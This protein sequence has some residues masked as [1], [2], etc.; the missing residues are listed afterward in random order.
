[1]SDFSPEIRNAAWWS[2]D[3]RLAADGRAFDAV[4][5]KLGKKAREDISHLEHVRMGHV[6]QPVIAK[7][8]EEEHKQRVVEFD[9]AVTHVTESWLRSHF[10]YITEDRRTLVECKN[11]NAHA[12]NKFSEPGEPVRIPAADRA[13]CIHEAT[14]AGVNTVYLAVLFGGQTFRSFRIDVTDEDKA[15]LVREMAVY[16]GMV[17]T[18]Q[19]PEPQTAEQARVAWPVDDGDYATAEE[20]WET[21]CQKLKALKTALKQMEEDAD[22]LQAA[23]QK[24][25]QNHSELRTFDGRTLATWK[26]TKATKRFDAA[27]LKQAMPDIYEKFVVEQPG[28]RRFLVK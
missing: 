17:Q 13:Q 19:L 24:R 8:W 22:N 5:Y 1:M 28:S 4:A 27:L 23:I 14:V 15:A 2:G 9:V 6:M 25:M 11:Y 3:S 20:A 18:N 12:I 7:L 10:D 16:W 21:A 26:A